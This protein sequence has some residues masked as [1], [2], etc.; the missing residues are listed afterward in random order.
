MNQSREAHHPAWSLHS[1]EGSQSAAIRA[2]DW[3]NEG[4]DQPEQPFPAC[5]EYASHVRRGLSRATA[6]RSWSGNNQAMEL[7]SGARAQA[8]HGSPEPGRGF[9]SCAATS[10]ATARRLSIAATARMSISGVV[11]R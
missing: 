2:A 9:V 10:S 3:P 1:P 7:A 4:H 5:E 11:S 8:C 6:D